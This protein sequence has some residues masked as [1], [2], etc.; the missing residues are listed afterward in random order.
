MKSILLCIVVLFCT[1]N[2]L[3]AV[4]N[5][6]LPDIRS[7]GMGYNGVTQSLLFN[8]SLIADS[9]KKICVNYYN[10]YALK[11]LGTLN[12]SCYYPN[13]FLSTG[14]DI[15]SF[16]YDSYRES[17]FR[18]S[19]GKK[20]SNKWSLGISIQYSLLQTEMLENSLSRISADMGI[21][22][23][24]VDKLLIGLLI[25][26]FPSFTIDNE[27]IEIEDFINYYFQLGFQWKIINNLL[28]AGTVET[29]NDFSVDLNLGIEY[30]IYESFRIRAGIKEPSF[31]PTAGIGYSFSKFI[32]DVAAVYHPVLGV[33]TGIGFSFSF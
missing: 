28:I 7:V 30:N 16:G 8:P 15:L 4:D 24:P 6:R 13:S 23:H 18:L 9:N 17:L 19:F 20:L 25:M 3:Y 14:I 22:F 26:N 31:L 12:M 2:Y 27:N 33:N 5:L 29:S 10:R 21:T 1:T 11:E 32:V